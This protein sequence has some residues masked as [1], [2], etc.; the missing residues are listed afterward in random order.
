MGKQ[1]HTRQWEVSV[2]LWWKTRV[3]APECSP[4]SGEDSTRPS[5]QC[6]KKLEFLEGSFRAEVDFLE[7]N[8]RGG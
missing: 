1:A 4:A 3:P 5:P 6:K 2:W 7:C 8:P